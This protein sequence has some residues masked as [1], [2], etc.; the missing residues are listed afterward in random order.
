MTTDPPIPGKN[1]GK[2]LAIVET[3]IVDGFQVLVHKSYSVRECNKIE[4]LLC[5]LLWVVAPSSKTDVV[6]EKA[7][8]FSKNSE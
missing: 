3:I 4:A 6:E 7:N 8:S 2:V 5:L 1:G